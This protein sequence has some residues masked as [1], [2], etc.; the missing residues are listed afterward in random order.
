MIVAERRETQRLRD[1]VEI[2]WSGP[3]TATSS[4]RE[5]S[6]VVRGLFRDAR[7]SV[8]VANYAFDRP[9]SAE[10]KAHARHLF[11]PLAENM[12]RNAALR[13]RFVVNIHRPH[14]SQPGGDRT[15]AALVGE[16]ADMFL[17]DLWPGERAPEI[18]YDPRGL[19]PWTD[20]QRSSMH[21]KCLVVDQEWLLV[22]SAN[23]TQA[24]QERN[25][26]A[27]VLIHDPQ[28]AA[29]LTWQFDSLIVHG[30]L[31]RATLR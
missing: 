2:V 27:G 7:S 12:D 17:R 9:K 14:P 16:F 31:A 10:A 20:G 18:Y 24:A 5:T 28:T 6:V 8:L 21:A 30:G 25:I 26:E 3:E 11:A 15:G 23:F 29:G 1:A 4:S 13:A 19:V 22:T